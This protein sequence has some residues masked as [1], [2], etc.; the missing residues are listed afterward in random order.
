M[1]TVQDLVNARVY[2]NETA[3]IQEA[4]RYLLRARPQLRLQVAVY[5]YQTEDISLGKAASLA[6]ISWAQMKD[7]L[8]EQ[9]I[10]P[11]LGVETLTEALA[12]IQAL[13]QELEG[14]G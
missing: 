9:G 13:Q 14:T 4:L 6:G 7:V 11:R 12:D 3:A 5:R 1:L 8:T 2:P 10:S